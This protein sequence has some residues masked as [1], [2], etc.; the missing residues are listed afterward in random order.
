MTVSEMLKKVEGKTTPKDRNAG[1]AAV[2]DDGVG[3][4]SFSHTSTKAKSKS[5]ARTITTV[6]ELIDKEKDL[7]R[8]KPYR[9]IRRDLME[10]LERNGT[11]GEQ[12]RGLV[13]DYMKMWV[14]K[15]KLAA[16]IKER[17][18]LV[19]AVGPGGREYLKKNDSVDQLPKYNAQ[20][21]KLL[22]EIGIK[23]DQ[24]TGDDDDL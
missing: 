11:V 10:Q 21:M 19:T 5:A 16:D 4:S 15:E 14:I 2:P 3:S 8:T 20:M 12:F 17:G 6:G 7:T 22:S 1:K 18:V 9:D 24:N 23:P 13:D